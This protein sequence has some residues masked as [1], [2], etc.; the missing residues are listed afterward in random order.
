M[1]KALYGHLGGT[2]ARLMHEIQRLRAR[3]ADLEAQVEQLELERALTLPAA[4]P[5]AT[6]E[7]LQPVVS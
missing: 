5:R 6:E 2:D 1:A 3:V 4:Q 7:F